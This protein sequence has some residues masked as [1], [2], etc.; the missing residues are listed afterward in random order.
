[1]PEKSTVIV[2]VRIRSEDGQERPIRAIENRTCSCSQYSTSP[3]EMT[4]A[5]QLAEYR[6]RTALSGDLF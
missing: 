3:E 5:E 2:E 4:K 6:H 1:M